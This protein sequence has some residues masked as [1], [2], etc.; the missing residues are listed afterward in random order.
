MADE[1]VDALDEAACGG[2]EPV[3]S[4]EPG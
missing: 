4:E 3:F 2:E 1:A